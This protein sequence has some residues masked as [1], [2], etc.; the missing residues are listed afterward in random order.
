METWAS[1]DHPNIRPPGFRGPQL[2]PIVPSHKPI[3]EYLLHIHEKTELIKIVGFFDL[4]LA[5]HGE[6]KYC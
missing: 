6:A 1:C 3:K 4:L 5:Q 2:E